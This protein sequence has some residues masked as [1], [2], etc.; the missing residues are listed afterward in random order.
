MVRS[1]L[2]LNSLHGEVLSK[3]PSPRNQSTMRE[4]QE[5]PRTNVEGLYNIPLHQGIW[6]DF[7]GKQQPYPLL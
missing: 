7:S 2:R 4:P 3:A 6:E 1:F 5:V